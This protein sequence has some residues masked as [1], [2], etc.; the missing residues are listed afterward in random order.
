MQ[1]FSVAFIFHLFPLV[2]L[3]VRGVAFEY[4]SKYGKA[5]WR[6]RWDI[7]ILV[8]STIPALLW[9]VAFANIVRGVPIERA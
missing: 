6:Q 5:Q 1:R 7:A 8:S 3:I 4:R 2:S 9:G